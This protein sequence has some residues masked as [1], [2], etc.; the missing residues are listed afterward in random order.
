MSEA[1]SVAPTLAVDE[2]GFDS[3]VLLRSREQPV[4]VDFWATWCAPC[5]Q[6]AVVLE[7][8]ARE[9][10]GRV[11]LAKVDTDL[12]PALAAR[13][14]VRSLPTLLLFRD[15]EPVDGLVGAH[16]DATLRDFLTRHLPTA[17]DARRADALELARTGRT[18]EA[19]AILDELV[20]SEPDRAAHALDLIDLLVGAG[21]FSGA[22]DRIAAL[23]LNL[24][25]DPLVGRASA[26]LE[27]AEL[28]AAEDAPDSEVGRRARAARELLAGNPEQGL[29]QLLALLADSR[30]E[31]GLRRSLRAAFTLLGAEH[32]AVAKARRRMA[33][34]LN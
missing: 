21:R 2:A 4:L 30:G 19:V 6:L 22:R 3:A 24:S 34:L 16:G 33:A 20:K 23:P 14:G 7:G 29:E 31:P 26:R 27:L 15:G 10:A 17:G 8:I 32:E 25:E 11:I 9:F 1:D 13:Y 5:R 28:A 12:W 18:D